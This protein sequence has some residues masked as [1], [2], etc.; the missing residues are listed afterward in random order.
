MSAAMRSSSR[1]MAISAP[2]LPAETAAWASPAL[3]LSTAFHIE[4][5]LPRRMAWAG[6][7]SMAMMLLEG[8]ISQ[9]SRMPGAN[10]SAALKAS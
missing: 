10:S 1:D 9:I 5:P 4:E 6:L 2:V 3:T 8:R 7:A